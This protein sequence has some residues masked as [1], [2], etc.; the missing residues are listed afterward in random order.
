MLVMGIKPW[1]HDT[2]AAIVADDGST[3]RT[4]AIS[5]A[6]LNREKHSEIFP[7]LSI[8]YCLDAFGLDSLDDLDLVVVD[9]LH[10]DQTIDKRLRAALGP[11]TS[12]STQL[13]LAAEASVR[14]PVGKTC[15]IN[16]VDSHLASAYFA[17]PFD[18]AAVL[19]VEGGFGLAT[20][21][22]TELALVDRT[23]YHG[24][25]WR[26]GVKVAED[27]GRP[28]NISKVYNMV[29]RLL[30]FGNFGS[31]KTMGMAAYRD[32]Y[33]ARDPIDLPGDTLADPF[34]DHSDLVRSY[35]Q[36]YVSTFP[37]GPDGEHLTEPRVN[38][39]RQIQDVFERSI[40]AMTSNAHARTASRRLALAGGGALSCVTNRLIIEQGLF[41]EVFVQP[42]SSDEGI[43]LGCA[44]WGYNV[45]LNGPRRFIMDHAYLGRPYNASDIDS[46]IV[47]AKLD[48]KHAEPRDIAARLAGG[49][50]IARFA[51]GS[52]YGPRALGN[53][54]ILADPRDPEVTQRLNVE[55][56]H[57]EPFR[58]F[59]A[60]CV[61]EIAEQYFDLDQEAPFMVV[62]AK[63]NRDHRT[64]MPAMTH[65][66]YSCR[67]QTV[68]RAQNTRYHDLLRAFEEQT[69]HAVLINTSFNDNDEPIVET[70]LDAVISAAAMN[71]DAIV[72]EDRLIE[73]PAIDASTL[74]R[75]RHERQNTLTRRYFEE[76][77]RVSE[78]AALK[79][80]LSTLS[81]TDKVGVKVQND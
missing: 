18:S 2:G 25:R 26:D 42:A 28:F 24:A 12:L 30:G 73:F 56:K 76:M 3:L 65:V 75:L 43:P 55:V 6:R 21:A 70:P 50:I 14:W 8:R 69:S 5:E 37:V 27:G 80:M 33:P 77:H 45:V 11:R 39:A 46:V 52:E 16:H 59:A 51:G 31:G 1:G 71:L 40:L 4:V 9:R 60:S 58:P 64:T 68:R 10:E 67:P 57:R 36:R 38:L 72:L 48:A 79:N 34:H 53:R 17:S 63:V 22:G 29:S 49:A 15:S 19:S 62:A 81:L 47:D 20:G 74:E 78:P 35:G 44:L 7:L 13:G 61:A 32:L 23:G 41:D 66:D 54:S